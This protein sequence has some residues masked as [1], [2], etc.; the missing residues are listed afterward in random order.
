MAKK[1]EVRR[2][3]LRKGV[4][5]HFEPNPD[6]D[7]E[8]PD[9]EDNLRELMYEPGQVVKSVRQLDKIFAN[10][11]IPYDGMKGEDTIDYDMDDQLAADKENEAAVE[12]NK[13][14]AK[15]SEKV[16][17]LVKEDSRLMREKGHGDDTE[18]GPQA[19]PGA[20]K[21]PQEAERIARVGSVKTT[22]RAESGAD[23]G[24]V[25]DE[26]EED[27]KSR[28]SKAKAEEEDEPE[29]E[30][31]EEEDEDVEEEEDLTRDFDKAKAAGVQVFK[32]GDKYFVH[33]KGEDGPMT[34]SKKGFTK[35]SEVKSFIAK[36]GGE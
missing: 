24:D 2:F 35:K 15:K 19:V 18:D 21:S 27:T 30:D 7:P 3:R 31:V 33:E 9:S 10:K 29:D 22:G 23:T 16:R 28:K 14:A 6:F 13:K 4:G 12:E 17:E 11:F 32:R 20:H 25:A 26:V 8:L 1:Q 34:G 36:Q 5:T